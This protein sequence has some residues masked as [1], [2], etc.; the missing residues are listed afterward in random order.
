MNGH[1]VNDKGGAGGV[2]PGVR[3]KSGEG[4]D[5]V[6]IHLSAR[7]AQLCGASLRATRDISTGAGIHTGAPGNGSGERQR[8]YRQD[9]A[10]AGRRGVRGICADAAGIRR[11]RLRFHPGGLRHGVQI[12][13]ERQAEEAP[14]PFRRGNGGAGHETPP[15]VF[16]GDPQ[17]HGHGDRRAVR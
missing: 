12:L 11:Q 6:R 2:V 4:G 9:T 14:E 8:G 7:T 3:R 15:G 5:T 16:R 13:P 10:A 17:R 1:L